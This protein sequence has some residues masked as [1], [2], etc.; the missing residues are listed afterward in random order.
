MPG[1][2]IRRFQAGDRGVSHRGAKCRVTFSASAAVARGPRANIVFRPD[3]IFPVLRRLS[4]V[5]VVVAVRSGSRS[6][7]ASVSAV[8]SMR[9]RFSTRAR[10]YVPPDPTRVPVHQESVYRVNS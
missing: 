5:V 6:A 2:T 3:R 1:E 10:P 8:I 7:G 9:A 4:R